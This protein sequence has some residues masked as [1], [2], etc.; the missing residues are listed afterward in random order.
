VI[1]RCAKHKTSVLNTF[2]QGLPGN[3][4]NP[5]RSGLPGESG[6][7]GPPG[8]DGLVGQ[9]GFKGEAGSP[10]RINLSYVNFYKDIDRMFY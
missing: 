7:I 9:R 2:T 10:G 5:G 8:R 3:D 6:A 4:G 1:T